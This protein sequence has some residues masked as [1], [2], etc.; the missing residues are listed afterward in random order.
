MFWFYIPLF[1]IVLI[2]AATVGIYAAVARRR[3][4]S[5]GRVP[6][7]TVY[8]AEEQRKSPDAPPA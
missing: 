1:I 5:G 8:D 2:I 7:Q 4:G 6:G 3:G